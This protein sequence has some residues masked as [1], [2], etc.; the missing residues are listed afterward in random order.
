MEKHRRS[1]AE[2]GFTLLE[3]VLSVTLLAVFF[4][5]VAVV[6]AHSNGAYSSARATAELQSRAERATSRVAEQLVSTSLGVLVPDPTSE[7]G[8]QDLR[9]RQA[10][11][12]AGAVTWSNQLELAF[13]YEAEELDDGL[14]NNGNGL[15]D[16]GLLVLTRDIGG[17]DER[18]VVLCHG[19]AELAEGETNNGLDDNG[20]GLKDERGF[21]VHRDGDV[22]T[23]GL[24]VETMDKSSPH[25]ELTQ[26]SMTTAVRLRN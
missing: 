8:V 12:F 16:A 19:V 14:D 17:P 22:L 18:R 24:T 1:P 5:S 9:F 11:G 4:G 6:R 10:E 3:T 26:R 2:H 21:C 20:N 15:E 13:E 23:I 25:G 7:F